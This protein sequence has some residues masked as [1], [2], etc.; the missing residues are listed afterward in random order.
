MGVIDHHA[1]QNA[2]IVT[3]MPIYIDIRPWGSMSSIITH[4]FLNLRRRPKKSTAGLMLCAILSDTLNLLS[5]TTT[6]WDRLMVSVLIE[7]AEVENVQFL[8]SQQFKAKSALL[9]DLSA[10]A[11]ITGDQKI[12]TYQTASFD[13]SVAFAVIETTDDE[14][15]L[16]RKG[17]LLVALVED[18]EEKG[19]SLSYLAIVN[20][21]SLHSTLLLCGPNERHLASIAFPRGLFIT[22]TSCKEPVAM[23]IGNLVSRKKDFIP[24]ISAAMKHGYSD[25][26][27]GKIHASASDI[28]GWSKYV[29]TSLTLNVTNTAALSASE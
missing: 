24:A 10:S 3:D 29:D 7:L 20:I 21:L 26:P 28:F 6:E 9:G 18:K 13:G 27:A 2:T 17:E 19:V 5:P 16:A 4:S 11:L 12:F 23:D 25:A 8:A 15:I 14:I 1:L 22:E